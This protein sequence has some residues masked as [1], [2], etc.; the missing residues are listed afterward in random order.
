M[1]SHNNRITKLEL[2]HLPESGTTHLVLEIL[3]EYISDD[4]YETLTQAA[5]IVE[6]ALSPDILHPIVSSGE[7][8]LIE[9]AE[10]ILQRVEQQCK[11]ESVFKEIRLDVDMGRLSVRQL[12]RLKNGASFFKV[13][14]DGRNGK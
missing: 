7:W 11:A 3:G 5:V 14:L 12:E 10:R 8:A 9:Q 4:D 6:R 1:S 2:K 13:M